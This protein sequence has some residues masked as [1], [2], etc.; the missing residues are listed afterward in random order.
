MP[1]MTTKIR[2]VRTAKASRIEDYQ[3]IEDAFFDTW[4]DAF[5]WLKKHQI[6][7]SEDDKNQVES[8]KSSEFVVCELIHS[9]GMPYSGDVEY[10]IEVT[11]SS[12]EA[13]IQYFFNP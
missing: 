2:I 4:P 8:H 13:T 7:L 3:I 5:A 11:K 10:R 12:R 1:E 6:K 9:L